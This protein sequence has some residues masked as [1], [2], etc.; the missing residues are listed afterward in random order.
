M[1]V[2]ACGW[3]QIP[4]FYLVSSVLLAQPT[5]SDCNQFRLCQFN[6]IDE[7]GH[8]LIFIGIV[9]NCIATVFRMMAPCMAVSE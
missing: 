6:G 3:D 8:S 9:S 1:C 7:H 2:C 4:S 5:E